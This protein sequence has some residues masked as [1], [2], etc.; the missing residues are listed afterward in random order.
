MEA[1]FNESVKS[2]NKT[3]STL[4]YFERSLREIRSTRAHSDVVSPDRASE[5]QSLT[6]YKYMQTCVIDGS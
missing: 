3:Q 4:R 2:L 1:S 5:V 6:P